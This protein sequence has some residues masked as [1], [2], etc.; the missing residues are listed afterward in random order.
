MMKKSRSLTL[1]HNEERTRDPA[2]L[3]RVLESI[4]GPEHAKRK[5][6]ELGFKGFE[7]PHEMVGLHA[8][9]MVVDEDI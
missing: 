7:L 3:Y 4:W 6:K 9:V 2:V 8:G 1:K 5:M